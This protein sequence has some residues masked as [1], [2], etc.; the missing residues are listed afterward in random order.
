M[1]TYSLDDLS[2]RWTT[3][4]TEGGPRYND[5]KP[6]RYEDQRIRNS[7]VHNLWLGYDVTPELNVYAGV[8]NVTNETW[9]DNPFTNWGRLNYSLLGRAYYAGI[10]YRF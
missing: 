4:F 2:I 8:N 10:N 1:A 3:K 6:D 5:L 9:L 7:I